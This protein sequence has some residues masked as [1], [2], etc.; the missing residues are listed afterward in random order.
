M[1][2]SKCCF[3]DRRDVISRRCPHISTIIHIYDE[4]RGIVVG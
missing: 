1:E 4:A 3:E 2:F